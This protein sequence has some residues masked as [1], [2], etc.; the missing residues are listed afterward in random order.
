MTRAIHGLLTR[1]ASA[2]AEDG[3]VPTDI[4]MQLGAEGY[5]LTTLDADVE[6]IAATAA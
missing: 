5:D 2:F 1:A 6:R 3:I 4:A